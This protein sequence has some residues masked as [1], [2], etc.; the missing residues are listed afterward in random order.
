MWLTPRSYRGRVGHAERA[1][2]S[3]LSPV[4]EGVAMRNMNN[5]RS[6]YLGPELEDC[7][8][9]FDTIRKELITDAE[10]RIVL[11]T[12]VEPKFRPQLVV[13]SPG[14]DI[15][16]GQPK[17]HVWATRDL[18]ATVDAISYRQLYDLLIQAYRNMEAHLAGQ[19]VIPLP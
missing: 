1:T 17:L 13:V 3:A 8:K 18:A 16:T 6:G 4:R 12:V 15:D 10:I 9:C 7:I 11:P 5:S 14:F 19:L 2:C